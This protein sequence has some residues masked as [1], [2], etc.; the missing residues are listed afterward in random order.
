MKSNLEVQLFLRD[1][2]LVK[3]VDTKFSSSSLPPHLTF[4]QLQTQDPGDSRI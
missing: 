4:L 2:L 3:Y 1:I